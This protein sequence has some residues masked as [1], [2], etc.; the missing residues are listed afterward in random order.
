[1]VNHSRKQIILVSTLSAP[2]RQKKLEQKKTTK[3]TNKNKN[4]NRKAPLRKPGRSFYV[5][6]NGAI[7]PKSR[8][9]LKTEPQ[10]CMC[11]QK[12]PGIMN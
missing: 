12:K 5:L 9:K 2:L 10:W 3:Q 7:K 8:K 4:Q 6:S 11:S 1:M